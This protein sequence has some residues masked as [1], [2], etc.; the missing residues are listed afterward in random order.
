MWPVGQ[1]YPFSG[2]NPSVTSLASVCYKRITSSHG[3]WRRSVR[4]CSVVMSSTWQHRVV[5]RRLDVLK[6]KLWIGITMYISPQRQL[7]GLHS[8]PCLLSQI[9]TL[10]P[11]TE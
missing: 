9:D 7:D 3:V 8:V 4:T 1:H 11:V 5:P 2:K 10:G 6:L